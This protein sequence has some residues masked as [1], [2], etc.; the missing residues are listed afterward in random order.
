VYA[1]TFEIVTPVTVTPGTTAVA[2]TLS[3]QAC[4]DRLCYLPESIPVTFTLPGP[5]P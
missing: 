1:K 4:D 3:Y 2:G 5:Q